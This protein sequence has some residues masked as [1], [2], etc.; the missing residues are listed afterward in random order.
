MINT[1]TLTQTHTHTLLSDMTQEVKYLLCTH[2][3]MCLDL[4]YQH[5]KPDTHGFVTSL[6]VQKLMSNGG[7]WKP[8]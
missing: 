5:K 2:E 6:L 8:G 3:E 1:N 4:S 7:H